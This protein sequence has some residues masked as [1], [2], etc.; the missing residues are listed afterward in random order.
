VLG[1]CAAQVPRSAIAAHFHASPV[2]SEALN[3]IAAFYAIE[4]EIRLRSAEERQQ[5]RNACADLCSTVVSRFSCPSF[6]AVGY[7]GG[8]SL[9]PLT[10][11]CI[12]ALRCKRSHGELRTPD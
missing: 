6:R 12:A 1:K 7:D 2:A 3:R 8:D 4:K 9:R 11:G 10:L 5:I